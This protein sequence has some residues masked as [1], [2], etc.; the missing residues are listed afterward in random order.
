MNQQAATVGISGVSSVAVPVTDQERALA[1]YVD[2][3]GLEKR[4]DAEFA[5]GNRW[6]EVGPRGGST[7]IALPPLGE[8]APGVDTGIRLTTPDAEAEHA[9]LR[10]RGVSV[11]SEVLRFGPGVPPMF[12]LRDPDGNKLYVVEVPSPEG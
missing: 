10:A 1:F 3:L 8:V 5:P 2:V 12:T 7:T 6:I 9:A 4:R 11:D